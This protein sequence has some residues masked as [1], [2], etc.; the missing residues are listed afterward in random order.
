MFAKQILNWYT[1]NRRSFPWRDNPEAYAVWV[2]EVMAQQTRLETMLPYFERWMQRFPTVESL[3]DASQHEVLNLWEGLG[4]YSRARNLH[5]AAHMLVEEYGGEIPKTPEELIRLPGIGAYTAGA[6]SSIAFGADQPV[7][8]GN[9]KRVMARIFALSEATNTTKG[10]KQIWALAREQLPQGQAADY[11]Q[12]LMELG[13]LVCTPRKPNCDQC[14]ITAH[15]QAYQSGRQADFPVRV[16]RAKVP[17]HAVTAAVIWREEQVLI[18]QRAQD[19]MLGGMWEFP[20]G[21]QEDGETLEKCLK[22]EIKEELGVKIKVGAQLGIFQHAYTHFKVTLHA[23]E[24]ELVSSRL[25]LN[26]HQA[27]EW[28]SP[29]A[30][31]EYPMGKID[32]QISLKLQ[33]RGSKDEP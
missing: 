17:H 6:I 4:Y 21:K 15:C 7:V 25:H 12:A 5:R 23:F 1:K 28:V 2:S 9:V 10:E 32:R 33:T 26:V 8:D 31:N 18:G 30:L 14:P 20:G 3:A 27:V 11:N 22:R 13:A 16:R 19:E 29:E 24:C